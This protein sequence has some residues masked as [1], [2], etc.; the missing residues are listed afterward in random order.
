M[1]LLLE[2]YVNSHIDKESELL[3]N[4]NRATHLSQTNPRMCSGH[5]QGRILSMICKLVRPKYILELGTYTGYSALCM[6][7]SLNGDD[8]ELH[9]IDINDE[10]EE[11]TSGFFEQ[12]PY[13]DKIHFH[14]GDAMEIIPTI[15]R[16]FDIV[17]IDANKRIYIEYYN[18]VI[19]K[20]KKGGLIIADNTLWDNKVIEQPTPIDPQS[21]GIMN[22]NDMIITDDRVEVVI[23]PIRDG[24]TLIR[25]K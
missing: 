7:E 19:D 3:Y 14:I 23:L 18:M 16:E 13:G 6:A 2:E 8:A 20:V 17:F 22:F 12:S 25:K 11:F 24:M 4:L 21:V 5:L 1:D 10:I 9:T 15:D